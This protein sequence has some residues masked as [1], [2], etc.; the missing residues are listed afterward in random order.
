MDEILAV[1]YT[2]DDPKKLYNHAL[3]VIIARKS[4][5]KKDRKISSAIRN[6]ISTTLFSI[7]F[8][9]LGVIFG[10]IPA[11]R[12]FSVNIFMLGLVFVVAGVFCLIY[13]GVMINKAPCT[14]GK[15]SFS[16]EGIRDFSSDNFEIKYPWEIYD[17]TVI[18]PTVI[19]IFFK[20]SNLALFL[21]DT[22]ES[23][24]TIISA[25]NRY[26]KPDSVYTRTVK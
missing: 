15:I 6:S 20:Q 13:Y 16:A 7:P 17:F 3:G 11:F 1:E 26:G 18:T 9:A 5:K 19:V 22:Y 10:M 25:L 23:E 4:L 21:P 12:P 8:F 24:K 2:T 14:S